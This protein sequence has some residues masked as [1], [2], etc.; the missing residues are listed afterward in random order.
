MKISSTA[1]A[2]TLVQVVNAFIVPGLAQ[3]HYIRELSETFDNTN[4]P[5]NI[6]LSCDNN[7]VVRDTCCFEYPGGIL[8][9]TQFWDYSPSVG[10]TD[11]FTAHGLWPDNCSKDGSYQQF[12]NSRLNVGNV[13]TVL[14]S[15][16]AD[17]LLAQMK[18]Y[19]K[20]I[21]G[22][23]ASL[24]KH[25]FNKH[26]TCINTI[27]PSCYGDDFKTNQNVYDY[28]RIV[29]NLYSKL[30]TYQWLSDAGI[31]P[32]NSQTYT[33]SEISKA[34]ADKFGSEVYIACDRNNALNEV[35]YFHQLKGSLLGEQFQHI[36]SFS[37]SKC[38][39]SGIKFV[40]KGDSSTP[41]T[42]TS[43]SQP[44][45][46]NKRGYVKL[47]DQ[48]GCLIRSGQWY[49]SGTCATYTL[50]EA[51]FGGYNLRSGDGYCA[52]NDDGSLECSK[53][54]EAYQFG[55]DESTNFISVNGNDEWHA[56]KVPSN[57]EKVSVAPGSGDVEFKLKF[58]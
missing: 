9:Q 46:G 38:P 10:P 51:E 40:P 23:D 3:L 27:E 39:D 45:D 26:G 15:F 24:W 55:Y 22:N 53:S 52:L 25:E 57:F 50:E 44:T 41:T 19:W 37:E 49:V 54:N 2:I 6:P 42:S 35:W 21:N 20:N 33:K 16:G 43:S 4:C 56:D 11:S 7:T 8:L 18:K 1:L 14:E 13:E 58:T 28:F 48:S 32:S 12:C 36:D 5:T 30:P 34:L 47:T 17:D 29:M 31:V